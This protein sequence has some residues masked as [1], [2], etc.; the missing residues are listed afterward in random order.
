[1]V[2]RCGVGGSIHTFV[3]GDIAKSKEKAGE[4]FPLCIKSNRA[5]L[6]NRNDI[7][8]VDSE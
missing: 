7:F 3:K 4:F 6:I 8:T 5:S 2:G 1:M